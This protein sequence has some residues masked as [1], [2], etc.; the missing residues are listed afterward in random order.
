MEITW[1]TATI[2]LPDETYGIGKAFWGAVTDTRPQLPPDN[3]PD[4]AILQPQVG[5]P[6]LWLQRL[7]SD[8][9]GEPRVHLD[10]DVV[11][12]PAAVRHAEA[13]GARLVAQPSYAVLSSPAGVPFCLLPASGPPPT[14]MPPARWP[15]G[16]S[17]VDQVCLDLAPDVPWE[18]ELAFW[19]ELTGW[20]VSSD[21]QWARLATPAALPLRVLLQRRYDGATTSHLDVAA[22]DR[23]AEVARWEALG[24]RVTGEGPR[25]TVMGTPGGLVACVT[26]RSP[27]TGLLPQD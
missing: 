26:Q 21:E 2:D 20:E 18:T 8:D 9:E 27:D 12:L 3:D 11:D 13:V 4:Y 22:D 10:L 19:G 24:A 1:L 17:L 25:W 23:A 14:P 7:G 6:H 15:G 5:T 16:R